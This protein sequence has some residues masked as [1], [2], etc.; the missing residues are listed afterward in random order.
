[1]LLDV[2]LFL[3]NSTIQNNKFIKLTT[4][5]EL[6]Q[7]FVKG[8]KDFAK[9]LFS[10]EF[11]KTYL[12]VNTFED[13]TYYNKQR[14]EDLVGWMMILSI[15]NYFL[16]EKKGKAVKTNSEIIHYINNLL[17]LN[18]N[19]KDISDKCDYKFDELKGKLQTPNTKS[20]YTN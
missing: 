17:I 5:K 6:N 1:L 4:K 10:N 8:K 2:D 14:F 15:M 12:G 7:Y 13:I 3:T 9:N 18:T 20:T 19:L 11:T 16:I